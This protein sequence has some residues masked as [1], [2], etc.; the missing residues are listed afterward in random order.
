MTKTLKGK[1]NNGLVIWAKEQD[2]AFEELK[3]RF[4]SAP[5]LAH[6]Y[7]HR[8]T[9]IETDATDFALG[10]ILSQYLGK[11]LHPVAFHSRKVNDAERNYIIHDKELLAILDA[12]KEWKHYIL[13]TDEPV[14]V[15][16]D[17]QNLQYFLTT[18]VWNPRQIRWAQWLAN[19]NFKIV[20][21]PGSRSGK[22]DALSRLPEYRL[23]GAA[24]H[25]ERSIL[26]PEHFE[27]S[28]CPRKDR[29]PISLVRKQTPGSNWPRIKR[30]SRDAKMPTKGSRMAA[31]HDIYALEEGSIPA[32]GQVLVRTGI[33]VGLPKGTYGALA[34]RSGMGSKN[35]IV[36]GGGVIDADCTREVKVILQNQGKKDYQFKAGYRI[37]RVIVEK[38]QLDEAM[39]V[40]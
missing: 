21:G 17:H 11:R 1:D 9:V 24:T 38:V 28:V 33:A 25:C 31:G 2:E 7:P 30:L 23:E 15:Y 19:I 29:I 39:E 35:G 22:P 16:T 26:K 3:R 40:N 34:A 12:F 18:K 14:T 8:R 5:I 20:Y 13:G 27:L 37:A 36:V 4:T 10:A 32:K 6:F